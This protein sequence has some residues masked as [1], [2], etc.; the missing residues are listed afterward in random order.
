M[1][2]RIFFC[3][4]GLFLLSCNGDS[5][6]ETT[7]LP[8]PPMDSIPLT[9]AQQ[10]IAANPDSILL[11][12]NLIQQFREKGNYA[13]ALELVNT[14]L[15]SDSTNARLWSIKATLHFENNDTIQSIKAYE[16]A[17]QILPITSDMVAL[18]ILYAVT[19]N[20]QSLTLADAIIKKDKLKAERQALFIKGLFNSSIGKEKEAIVYFNQCIQ[21]SYTFM[22]AY[23]EK[24]L[25]LM[26]LR[27]FDQ[28]IYTLTKAVT[29][30]NNYEEGY[31]YLGQCYELMN[32]K[33]EAIDAYQKALL[34]SPDYIEAEEALSR[35]SK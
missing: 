23:R 1:D 25:S 16:H 29:I 3:I 20:N 18:G 27:E 17:L 33:S 26:E 10:A 30:Q 12:E 19:K 13:K 15:Q 2:M 34:Y 28:A 35:L 32:K 14:F 8:T 21:L 31:Y 5:K 22:E 24:A 11:K 4:I 9:Q 7:A 6:K